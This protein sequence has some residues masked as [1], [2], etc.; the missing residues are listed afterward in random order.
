MILEIV[1]AGEVA[2][3]FLEERFE[4]TTTTQREPLS[5]SIVFSAGTA[6][7]HSIVCFI[8]IT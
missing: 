6:L 5:I 3:E 4:T 1:A 8:F 7:C 2:A